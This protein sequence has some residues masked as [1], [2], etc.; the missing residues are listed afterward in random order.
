MSIHSCKLF[1]ISE[2]NVYGLYIT[3]LCDG[4]KHVLSPYRMDLLRIEQD[5][6]HDEH[7]TAAYVQTQLEDVSYKICIKFV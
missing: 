1:I 7:L 3:A 2:N 4:L 6:L 5:L